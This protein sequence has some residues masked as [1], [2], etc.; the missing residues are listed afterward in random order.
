MIKKH[1]FNFG[2]NYFL[3]AVVSL[4]E[5]GVM[6]KGINVEGNFSEIMITFDKLVASDNVAS[7]ITEAAPQ[8][9]IVEATAPQSFTETTQ[10][11]RGRGRPRKIV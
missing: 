2:G 9:D 11:K 5:N 1:N 7:D 4:H 6:A 8:S 3:F 10:I